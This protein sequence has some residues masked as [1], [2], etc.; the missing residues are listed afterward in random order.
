MSKEEQINLD[1]VINAYMASSVDS[2]E[3]MLS[4]WVERYPQYESELRET[5]AYWNLIKG[6]QPHEYTNEEEE[7]LISRASSIV[8]NI[9]F[10]QRKGV[11]TPVEA[12]SSLIDECERQHISLEEFAEA[13]EMSEP[14]I[15]VFDRKQVNYETIPRKAIENISRVL[16]M[17][18]TAIDSYFKGEMTLAP[19]HYRSDQ[20]PQ[21][22]K[23]YDFSYIVEIDPNLKDGQKEYWLAQPPYVGETKSE[24]G[25]KT[26]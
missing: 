26:R 10:Q 8:Q 15:M 14:M 16:G 9:L 19:A 24:H 6:V 18:F 1:D 25:G 12:P 2:G 13:A 11:S 20:Q 23:K 5:A 17:L 4:E 21:A 22:V 7:L 3:D